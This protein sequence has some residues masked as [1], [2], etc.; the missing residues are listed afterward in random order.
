MFRQI[1]AKRSFVDT[2]NVD[3]MAE[4]NAGMQNG[5]HKKKRLVVVG[6]GMIASAFM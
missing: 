2:A 3:S 4:G 6:L 1:P 5:V